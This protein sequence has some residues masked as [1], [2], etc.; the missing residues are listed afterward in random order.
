MRMIAPIAMLLGASLIGSTVHAD[1]GSFRVETF[2]AVTLATLQLAQG[3]NVDDYSQFSLDLFRVGSSW[4]FYD[5]SVWITAPGGGYTVTSWA[6]DYIP[7]TSYDVQ[8]Y[9]SVT[10]KVK[11][12]LYRP[13]LHIALSPTS[14]TEGGT[15]TGTITLKN[16]A[17]ANTTIKNA[18]TINLTSGTPSRATVP[19]TISIPANTASAN[20]TITAVNN[21][22]QDGNASVTISAAAG[23][24]GSA[25][26]AFTVIDND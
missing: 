12:Y 24:W 11:H 21:A 17:G 23:S 20:F 22:I 4:V 18:V 16:S 25:S 14:A 10:T 1:T 26:A 5:G 15:A 3:S 6:T 13:V 9:T 19:A 2:D 7:F 8:V